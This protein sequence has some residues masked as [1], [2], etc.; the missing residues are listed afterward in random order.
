MAHSCR[1]NLDGDYDTSCPYVR[2]GCTPARPGL[3]NGLP[4]MGQGEG[5]LGQSAWQ[6]REKWPS[7]IRDERECG[8]HPDDPSVWSRTGV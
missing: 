8:R 5:S 3:R 4:R 7:Q 2:H 1:R 6:R